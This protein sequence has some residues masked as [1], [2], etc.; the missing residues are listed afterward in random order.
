ML[1]Y[2]I[3]TFAHTITTYGMSYVT[4]NVKKSLNETLG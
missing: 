1:Q 2:I 4:D 3:A